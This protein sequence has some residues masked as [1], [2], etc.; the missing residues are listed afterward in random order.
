MRIQP[1][2]QLLDLWRALLSACYRDGAWVWGGRDGANSISDAEQ[3]LCLLY[4]ATE[5]AAF[6][7]DR[8]DDVRSALAPLGEETRIGGVIVGVLEDYVTRYTDTDGES[9]FA[10]GGYLRSV[11]GR[12]PT[13]AQLGLEVVD[14]YSM[15]LTLCIAALRFLRVFQRFVDGQV[16]KEAKQLSARVDLLVPLISARLTAAMT[17]LVRSFVVHTPAPKSDP[18]HAILEM[19]NQTGASE[20][21]IIAGIARR[22]ERV[23]VLLANDVKLGQT[24]DID[25]ADDLLLFECGWAWGIDHKAA[26][27]TFVRAK[28]A[29]QRGYAARPDLYFTVVA[30]DGINDLTSQRTRELDLL[31]DEQRMLADALQLRWDLTQ[32]Y[33]STVARYG[34]GRWP[35]EDVPWRTS[36]GE[37]SDYYSLA[38][39]A[40]LIQDLVN[41]QATDDLPRAVAVFD[42]LARRGRIIS[43]V[44][45]LDPAAGLHFPGVRLPMTGS[46][47]VDGG[48]PE[49][50]WLVPDFVT[51]LLKR[52]LQAARLSG[53]V[54]TRDRLIA[55][56]ES[57]MDHLDRRT[58]REGPAAGLW[59]DPARI[60][61]HGD[62]P[63]DRS[64]EA[65]VLPSWYLTERVVEC[66]VAAD[67]T[68]REP[69]LS[70]PAMISRAVELLNEAEHLLNQEMLEV[71]DQD[72]SQKLAAL[73]RI[74]QQLGKARRMLNERPGT[75]FSLA[76]EAL[77]QLDE[78]AYARHDATRIS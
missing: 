70:P 28:I 38:V 62:D 34:T 21:S 14:A 1:R 49:L 45:A 23:R 16:R 35:L 29:E 13:E 4:P 77:R 69:P 55:L 44:T 58:L 17:G 32:R 18:G 19:L 25:L 8:P 50:V 73:T 40:M 78:L 60:F 24:P 59:D 51:M 41:R 27:I 46:A 10:A 56:A 39:S 61:A 26:P 66:L 9:V 52:S 11:D 5:I 74:E 75:A 2:Q 64:R 71:S 6:A 57:A 67:R 33:W 72:V 42:Q 3:L 15:S 63:A 31:D 36:S 20:D 48:G 22:L 68:F 65:A 47:D 76:S 54:A 37:E 53:D 7:L 30:L 43:R 12:T